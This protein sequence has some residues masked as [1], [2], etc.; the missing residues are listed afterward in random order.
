MAL[1]GDFAKLEQL[2]RKVAA[3]KSKQLQRTIVAN[4]A[5]EA[6]NLI[7]EGFA[8]E[9]DPYRVPWAPKQR[10][11]GR[12]ILVRHGR[13]RRSFTRKQTGS[14]GFRIGSAVGYAGYHQSG[15]SRMVARRMVPVAGKLPPEWA[16]AFREVI[17]E[18]LDDHFS[19]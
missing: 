18:I 10:P 16:K 7:A 1:T 8:Q 15:T 5:Q 4:L 14:T 12:A 11:D 2:K 9:R 17:T 19:L 13:L 3:L 6:L